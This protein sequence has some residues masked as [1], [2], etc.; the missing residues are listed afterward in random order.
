MYLK[1]LFLSFF[2]LTIPTLLIA[3]LKQFKL[4]NPECAFLKHCLL[5]IIL[6]LMAFL[7]LEMS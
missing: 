4:P 5:Y 7:E 1:F 3:I 6:F 2:E